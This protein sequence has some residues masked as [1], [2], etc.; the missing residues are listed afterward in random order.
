MEEVRERAEKLK[1]HP[2][3]VKRLQV[4]HKKRSVWGVGE[5]GVRR[6]RGERDEREGRER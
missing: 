3:L 4:R 6:E 2:A 5:E 1:K